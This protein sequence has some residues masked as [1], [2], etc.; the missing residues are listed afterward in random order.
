MQG[1]RPRPGHGLRPGRA[2]GGSPHA[3]RYRGSLDPWPPS[4]VP[5]W[6]VLRSPLARLAVHVPRPGVV[7]DV[8][9]GPAPLHAVRVP[10]GDAPSL[11]SVTLPA[12]PLPAFRS[13]AW[14]VVPPLRAGDGPPLSSSRVQASSPLATGLLMPRARGRARGTPSPPL[15]DSAPGWTPGLARCGAGPRRLCSHAGR[16]LRF[17]RPPGGGRRASSL[18]ASDARRRIAPD[19]RF[20]CSESASRRLLL[21]ASGW[22]AVG[23]HA[24]LNVRHVPAHTL[25]LPCSPP[26]IFPAGGG[27]VPRRQP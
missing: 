18:N 9:P 15:P 25:A 17:R 22:A 3:R 11:R 26:A 23:G 16:V 27:A 1:C 4:L 21:A 7:G 20:P 5:S 2:W 13:A 10:Q 19:G 12:W 6:P 14:S 8:L 24:V